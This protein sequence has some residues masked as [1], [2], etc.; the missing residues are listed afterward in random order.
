MIIYEKSRGDYMLITRILIISL[1]TGVFSTALC[2]CGAKKS[3]VIAR[4]NGE[5]ITSEELSSRISKLPEKYREVIAANKKS[6]LDELITDK[7]L[8][9]ESLRRG[10][11]KDKEVQEVIDEARK[12][13]LIAR[14]L[15]DEVESKVSVSDQ[16]VRDYYDKNQDEF[17]TPEIL[18]AS[19][20]MVKTEKEAND[21]VK[22]LSQGASFSDLARSRSI[23]PSAAKGGDVGYFVKGQL[24][25]DFE[26][27]CLQM[28]EGELKYV[29]KTRFGYH[30]I[31]LTERKRPT[32]E[33]FK[34]VEQRVRHDMLLDKRKKTFNQLVDE[35]KKKTDIVIDDK[36]PILQP[37]VKAKQ[38]EPAAVRAVNK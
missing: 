24:D 2:G 21:I 14:L 22:E 15:R 11:D 33:K 29:V 27:A 13:I 26:A 5:V 6:F 19:H 36:A 18:R 10:L 35:L 9:K 7:L 38:E 1:I 20:I 34:D 31:K 32:I 17:K 12:K 4:V 30:I 3:D 25:P 8:Y 28:R 37:K 16:E 23:D